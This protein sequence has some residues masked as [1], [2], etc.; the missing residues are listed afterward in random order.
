MKAEQIFHQPT[1]QPEILKDDCKAKR[2]YIPI[3]LGSK[4]EYA[5]SQKFITA[6]I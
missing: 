1:T 6:K 5:T 4:R 3:K 2:K